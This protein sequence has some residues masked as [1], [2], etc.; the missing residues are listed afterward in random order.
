MKRIKLSRW[1]R[2]NDM[3]YLSAWR[4]AQAGKFPLPLLRLDTGTILVEMPEIPRKV[5]GYVLY[6]RVSSHDQKDDLSRQMERLRS[7]AASHGL[8]VADEVMEIGSGLNGARKKLLSI[9]RG[10][11]NLVVE[12]K[13]RLSRFG[14]EYIEASLLPQDRQVLVLNATEKKMDLVQ[15]FVDVCTSMCARIYGN[16]S[17]KNRAKR[18]MDAATGSNNHE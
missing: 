4:M 3:S 17:A 7:F 8:Q 16:R 1:A 12:H 10:K 14:F 13:D 6:A 2:D 9:L 5:D 11:F 15:D 18:M